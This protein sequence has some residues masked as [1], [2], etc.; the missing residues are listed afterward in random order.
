MMKIGKF[1][2]IPTCWIVLLINSFPFKDQTFDLFNLKND[3]T[4]DWVVTIITLFGTS[5]IGF[6]YPNVLDWF[7]LLGAFC[8]AFLN[9]Y[10]PSMLFLAQFKKAPKRKWL[11]HFTW[12]WMIVCMFI[13]MCCSCG[14]GYSIINKIIF[15]K[16][17]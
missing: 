8:G 6:L 11:V 1:L 17:S 3:D 5:F 2:M 10:F 13:L 16:V 4:N 7:S 15:G 14:V 9:I 12:I